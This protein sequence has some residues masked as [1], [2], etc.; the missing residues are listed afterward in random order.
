MAGVQAVISAVGLA[1]ELNDLLKNKTLSDDDRR[2]LTGGATGN[3]IGSVA[4]AAGGAFLGTL[5]L[6]GVGTVIGG[7]IGS[8]LG[9]AG[10]RWAGETLGAW[11]DRTQR[12]LEAAQ[13][14]YEEVQKEATDTLGK[15]EE[16]IENI[17]R[18]LAEAEARLQSAKEAND[19]K[20]TEDKQKND[21]YEKL[22]NAWASSGARGLY[23]YRRPVDDLIVTPQGQFS[24]HPDDYI[25]AMK[26][27]AALAGPGPRAAPP[28]I[29]GGEIVLRSELSIDDKGYR[30]RQSAGR[31]T[32]PYKFAVGSAKNARL[33]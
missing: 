20:R 7:M 4:G 3:A 1:V 17:R 18:K 19:A 11:K 8:Q 15:T 24:T 22:M 30:L 2:K 9:G 23:G 27:P 21:A 16:E 13:S 10:G 28:V 29:V 12:E 25:F 32:T 33:I 14:N 5:I 31:N 6:P 26:N